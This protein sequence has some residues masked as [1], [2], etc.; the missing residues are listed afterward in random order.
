[1]PL[2]AGAHHQRIDLQ[3]VAPARWEDGLT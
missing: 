2:T 3:R 1:V